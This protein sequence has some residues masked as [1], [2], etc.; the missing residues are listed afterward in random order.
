MQ[1]LNSMKLKLEFERT[2]ANIWLNG[3]KP[4]IEHAGMDKN[5]FAVQLD[6][7]RR[8]ADAETRS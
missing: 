2:E 3:M 8:A 4:A 1:V 7:L 5:K 6:E